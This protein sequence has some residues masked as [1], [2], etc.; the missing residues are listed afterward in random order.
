[1]SSGVSSVAGGDAILESQLVLADPSFDIWSLGMTLYCLAA[2]GHPFGC[3][4]DGQ[5]IDEKD[6]VVI[7][8]WNDTFKWSKIENIPDPQ[9]RNLISQLLTKDPKKRPTIESVLSHPFI[10]GK[11]ATRM[12]GDAA[13]FD[14][15]L[16]YRVASDGPL[17][18]ALCTKLMLAEVRVWFDQ[19]CLKPG[20]PWAL[21]FC[22]GLA[23]SAI[24]IPFLSKNAINH[25]SN[26]RQSFEML[27]ESSPCDNFLLEQRLSLELRERGLI[28]KILPV[29]IGE[30]S[31]TAASLS[32][33]SIVVNTSSVEP[34]AAPEV[35]VEEHADDTTT[36]SPPPPPESQSQLQRHP[37]AVYNRYTFAG[38]GC[39]HPSCP[40]VV[41]QSVEERL[42]GNLEQL[43][44][45]FPILD[46][47]TVSETLEEI[48]SY[49]G[50]FAEGDTEEALN[51]LVDAIVD[52]V[53]SSLVYNTS[54]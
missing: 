8:N 16:S 44:L 53:R 48:V 20:E 31:N 21:G 14:V 38:V 32:T 26:N 1:V 35:N 51:A 39:S 18:Q 2:G 19:K 42:R 36:V 41:V 37:S 5:I 54:R 9:C 22:K 23:K 46:E 45:G 7:A 10:T 27:T 12:A 29:F 40:E 25:P 13:E 50:L 11:Q 3:G 4:S 49:Q 52:M 6:L 47:M 15:F 33:R 34:A 17:V 43:G 30:A 24:F 28:D